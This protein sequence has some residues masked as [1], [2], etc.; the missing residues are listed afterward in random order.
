MTLRAA[1]TAAADRAAIRAGEHTGPT[2]GL[3][4]GFAQANLVILRA[5]EALDF[6]RF[7]VRNPKPCPLLEVTDTGSP[8]PFGIAAD[9]DLRTDLPRYRVFHDGHLVDEPTDIAGQWRT[10]LVSFLLGCSFTF[11]WALAAAGLPIA[12]QV[13]GVNVP[14]YVT[15]RRCTP[16]GR[17][18]GP[19][20]VSMRPFPADTVPRAVEISARF[21]AMH[22][23]PVHIGDPAEIGISDLATPDFGDAVRVGADEVPVFWA[24]GVT[25]QAVAI[26]ARPSLAIFH[27][28]GHMFITDRRHGDFDNEEGHD[29]R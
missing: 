28:P 9:A 3:A 19:L 4:P 7:C 10:D 2:S 1:D 21:P 27:A 25:P 16:A 12:H 15:D 14:M 13:Q 18:D 8:H 29:H 26:E 5:D 20:V 23:A 24:C 17:F 6:L 11:E 22:G